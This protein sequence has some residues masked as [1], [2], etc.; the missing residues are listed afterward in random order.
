MASA[1]GRQ[2]ENR[3]NRLVRLGLLALTFASTGALAVTS[4]PTANSSR[5]YPPSCLS[6]PLQES[7]VGPQWSA[8]ITVPAYEQRTGLV[9]DTE[10][11]LVTLWRVPCADGKSALLGVFA[12]SQ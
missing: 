7:P 12:R 1:L 2:G 11:V 5:A 6:A 9:T 10:V 3:K 8:N 4:G